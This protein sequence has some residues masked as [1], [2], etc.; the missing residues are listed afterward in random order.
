MDHA[1]NIQDALRNLAGAV[2]TEIGGN[3]AHLLMLAADCLD[4]ACAAETAFAGMGALDSGTGNGF[5]D[6]VRGWDANDMPRHSSRLGVK[7][8]T[9]CGEVYAAV[10][11]HSR[12]RQLLDEAHAEAEE[13][14]AAPVKE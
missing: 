3:E 9:N 8:P 13:I 10:D 5:Y 14:T 7:F 11:A 4:A 2:S 6:L 12:F 1:T